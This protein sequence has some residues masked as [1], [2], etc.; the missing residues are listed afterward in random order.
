VLAG[1]LE[2]MPDG[3]KPCWVAADAVAAARKRARSRWRESSP[4][5]VDTLDRL[6]AALPDDAVVVSDM[7]QIAYAGAEIYDTRCG[8][9]WVHPVGYGTLGYGMPAAIGAT[10][11][12]PDRTVVALAGDYGFGFSSPELATAASA[13]VGLAT[14]VWNNRRLGQIQDDMDASG[15]PRTGVQV[16]PPDFEVFAKAH[17]ADYIDGTRSNADFTAMVD[18]A[19]DK[20]KPLLIEIAETA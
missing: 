11:G 2:V 15:I 7:T 3:E 18:G 10:L 5:I 9:G 1:L 4:Q 17:G 12:A 19:R 8:G 16:D 20:G 6:N 13:G 14:I